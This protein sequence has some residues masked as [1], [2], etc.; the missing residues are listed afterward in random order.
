MNWL[1]THKKLRLQHFEQI[2]PVILRDLEY[3]GQTSVQ[4]AYHVWL[5]RENKNFDIHKRGI[6]IV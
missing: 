1:F 2:S 3:H 4:V 5:H 6:F